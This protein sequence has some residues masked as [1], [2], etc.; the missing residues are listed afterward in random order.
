[1]GVDYS[2]GAKSLSTTKPV[3][4][5]MTC[6]VTKSIEKLNVMLNKVHEYCLKRVGKFSPS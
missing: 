4:T 2:A 1:M 5:T 3:K 6:S